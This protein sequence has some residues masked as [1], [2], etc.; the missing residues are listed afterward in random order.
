MPERLTTVAWVLWDC[1]RMQSREMARHPLA[2]VIGVV[3]P[4]VLI[5]VTM[6]TRSDLDSDE[7]M[8][9]LVGVVLTSLWNGTVWMAGGIL[10]REL[11]LGTLA[12]NVASVYPGFLVLL[13]K[14]LGAM[15]RTVGAILVASAVTVVLIGAPV[16][17]DEPV[18][19]LVGLV[20]VVLSG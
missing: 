8:R 13:G 19:L 11:E 9:L 12:S 15:V 1:A 20:T 14:S 18:L 16:E 7:S 5:L 10:Q 17:L 6:G 3:Q 4:A 2:L